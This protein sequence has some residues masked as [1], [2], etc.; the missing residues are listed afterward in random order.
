[1]GFA[2]F[3][4]R[5]KSEEVTEDQGEFEEELAAIVTWHNEHRPHETL[6]GRTPDE[7]SF[8]HAPA[9]EQPRFETRL[10]WPRGSPCAEPQAE[11]KGQPGDPIIIEIDCVANR[12]HLPVTRA[13][14]AAQLVAIPL[15]DL[16]HRRCA[17]ISSLLSLSCRNGRRDH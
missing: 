10:R 8:S 5:P 3:K 11:L 6:G 2:V 13:R 15:L 17:P 9:N 1:M 4:R 16:Q 7:V 12:R 14:H